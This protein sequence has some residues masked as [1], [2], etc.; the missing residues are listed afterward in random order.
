M[1]K[2]HVNNNALAKLIF[3]YALMNVAK[4]KHS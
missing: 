4:G 1:L 3:Y 2:G